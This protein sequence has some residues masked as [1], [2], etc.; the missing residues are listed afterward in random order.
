M[1]VDVNVRHNEAGTFYEVK[2]TGAVLGEGRWWPTTISTRFRPEVA[3][4][5]LA[6]Q[7]DGGGPRRAP[8]ADDMV[9]LPFETDGAA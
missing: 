4:K 6:R 2:V 5:R 9:E 3:V 7:F 1:S 8:D